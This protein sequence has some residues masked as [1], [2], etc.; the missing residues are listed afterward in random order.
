MSPTVRSPTAGELL[1]SPSQTPQTIPSA[2]TL[3]SY[4]D[5][6]A[7]RGTGGQ[8]SSAFGSC[9]PLSL[10]TKAPVSGEF[11]VRPKHADYDNL[12]HDKR[13]EAQ[14]QDG[15]PDTAKERAKRFQQEVDLANARATRRDPAGLFKAACSTDLL[16]LMDTTGSMASHITAAKEQVRSIVADIKMAFLNEAEIRI[17]VVAY[18]DHGDRGHLDSL[19]F[20]TSTEAVHAFLDGL[21]AFGGGGDWPED[22][23]GGI[24]QALV[25]SWKQQTRCLIH[26]A[27]EPGHGRPL[28][29][30]GDWQDNYI[31]PG[32]D[33]HRLTHEPL[34]NK[35][36]RLK[37][38][39]VFL[40]IT[41]DTDRMAL[42]FAQKYGIDNAK[43]SN[44]NKYH[45]ELRSSTLRPFGSPDKPSA[46]APQFIEEHLGTTYSALRHL[47]VKTVSKSIT[48]TAGRLTVALKRDVK[49]RAGQSTSGLGSILDIADTADTELA[50]SGGSELK[51]AAF[52][53]SPP[54]W[55][56]PG[57]LDERMELEGFSPA[58]L[59]HDAGTLREW[60]N[61]DRNIKLSAVDVV[62][63]ARSKP[64]AQGA[65]RT[66]SYA[67]LAVSTNRYVIKR[68][69]KGGHG[70]AEVAE[71]MRIQA[72]CKAFALE[73][74]CLLKIEPPLDFIVTSCF[75]NKRPPAHLDDR[76]YLSL[77]PFIEGEYV[78][79][80]SNS[81]W[82]NESPDTFNKMAQAFSHFT[83]ERSYGHI[84]VNDLQ[85]TNHIL[86]DPAV[87]TRDPEKFKLSDTNCGVEGFKYFFSTHECNLFCEQLD[88]KSKATMFITGRWEFREEWPTMDRTLC[89]SSKFC[90]RLVRSEGAKQSPR[91]P[92]HHWCDICWPQLDATSAKWICVEPGPDHEFE[93]SRFF[94]ESQGELVPRKC[95]AHR[96]KISTRPKPAALGSGLFNKL[97]PSNGKAQILGKKW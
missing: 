8:I 26:I 29:D 91:F 37:I 45:A 64:F 21:R 25:A 76:D 77:E 94:H 6:F 28:H 84:L 54:Q 43:L 31:V 1:K 82:V 40:R 61:S 95:S 55:Q 14:R 71:D 74:D 92:G 32:S 19:D 90:R 86:T 20:T 59:E 89:C 65:M 68:F 73:F 88:L 41:Q 33:P 81:G 4:D 57:W 49:S 30:L 70:L 53:M 60:M 17:A 22:A 13:A 5:L 72:L 46:I 97:K 39:Y 67:R 79:Y 3:P 36:I 75:E 96:E 62:V 48:R 35:L 27:D 66:A 9:P 52:E 16:F 34:L 7:R 2:G 24:Q 10:S 44:V 42:V 15:A 18:K 11:P 87:Q 51:A 12:R 83:F 78:K 69:K 38:N 47:V 85:G 56:T 80:N 23:L 93:V 63:H 50:S 58:V